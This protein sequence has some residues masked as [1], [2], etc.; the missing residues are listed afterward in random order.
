MRPYNLSATTVA[1]VVKRTSAGSYALGCVQE[2]G[3]G[4]CAL[5]VGRSDDDLAQELQGWVGE[6]A[7]YK[8]FVFSYAP[9]PKTAFEKECENYHDFGG[10][11]MLDNA[12]HP[13]RLD[14][15]DWLCPRCDCYDRS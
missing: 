5:Y 2:N 10:T 13:Q 9:D 15:T 1:E 14:E 8:A 6:S 12:G 3:N 4:F 11:E 7:R